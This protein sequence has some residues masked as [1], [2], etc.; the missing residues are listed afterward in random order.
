MFKLRPYHITHKQTHLILHYQSDI[1]YCIKKNKKW[2]IR[3]TGESDKHLII[4]HIKPSMSR[5]CGWWLHALCCDISLFQYFYVPTRRVR[6]NGSICA[7][8]TL[9]P[10]RTCSVHLWTCSEEWKVPMHG[11]ERNG[12]SPRNKLQKQLH[13]KHSLSV[14]LWECIKPNSNMKQWHN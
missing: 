12:W 13:I 3:P 7:S 4:T 8:L 2:N 10:Q 6:V 1:H 5:L 14:T 9:F 11:Q